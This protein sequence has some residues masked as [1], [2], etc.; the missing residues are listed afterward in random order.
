VS[1]KWLAH[2]PNELDLQTFFLGERKAGTLPLRT[3]RPARFTYALVLTPA[4]LE[5]AHS[6]DSRLPLWRLEKEGETER[7]ELR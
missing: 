1:L 6:G 2:P 3:P 4:A 5:S 7:E